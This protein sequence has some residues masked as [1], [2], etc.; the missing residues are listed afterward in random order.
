MPNPNFEFS[1]VNAV[2]IQ[3]AKDKGLL[4]HPMRVGVYYPEEVEA[5]LNLLRSEC[6]WDCVNYAG[7]V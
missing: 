2:L 4:H 6:T 3:K 7:V 5:L 1:E